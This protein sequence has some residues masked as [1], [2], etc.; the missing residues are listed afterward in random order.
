VASTTPLRSRIWPRLGT[1]GTTAVR[2]L[3]ACAARS[4]WRTTCR[5]TRR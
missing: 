3:S 4:S 2:L 5:Y 1:M